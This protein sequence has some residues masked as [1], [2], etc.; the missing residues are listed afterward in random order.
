MRGS[1]SMLNF[2]SKDR[3]K[4]WKEHIERITNE[5]YQWDQNV[6]AVKG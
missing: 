3:G 4:F 5:E 6:K 2:S 1:D